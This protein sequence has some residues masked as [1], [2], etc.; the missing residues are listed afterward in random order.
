MKTS[1]EFLTEFA[2]EIVHHPME[3]QQLI[4]GYARHMDAREEAVRI[5]AQESAKTGMHIFVSERGVKQI[6]RRIKK[7]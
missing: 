5:E 7:S 4:A 2:K 3:R 6:S 1:Q